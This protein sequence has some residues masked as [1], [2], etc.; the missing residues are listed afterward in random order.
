MIIIP[1]WKYKVLLMC[2]YKENIKYFSLCQYKVAPQ[3]GNL[4]IW[5]CPSVCL[6]GALLCIFMTDKVVQWGECPFFPAEERIL[7][8]Y[9]LKNC[10][11]KFFIG[12]S[13]FTRLLCCFLLYSKVNQ[14]NWPFFF[15]FFSHIFTIARTCK[16]PKCPSTEKWIE[17]ICYICIME[18][19][20]AIKRME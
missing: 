19:Y 14:L 12:V 4:E 8:I 17:K 3:N 13:W 10:L 1:S 5:V 2:Q 11:L 15:R 20:S 6:Q 16:Q 7:W 18:Y 9:I